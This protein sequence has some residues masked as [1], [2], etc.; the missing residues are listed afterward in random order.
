MF[1]PENRFYAGQGAA[2][3]AIGDVDGDQS[4][5]LVVLRGASS[6]LVI[7]RGY[8]DGTFGR[9]IR[10]EAGDRPTA[11]AVADLNGDGRQ[12]LAV[13]NRRSNSISILLGEPGEGVFL[14][15]KRLRVGK[16]PDSVVA[17]DFNDDDVQDQAAVNH[18]SGDMSVL[19]G[20]GGGRFR[21]NSR[22]GFLWQ[23]CGRYRLAIRCR[24]HQQDSPGGQL[25]H[26]CRQGLPDLDPGQ[27]LSH[28][29]VSLPVDRSRQHRVVQAR[30]RRTSRPEAGKAPTLPSRSDLPVFYRLQPCAPDI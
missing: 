9:E 5:D 19:I 15:Q 8:G 16:A 21:T 24:K 14:A 11:V 22:H 7:L 6:E 1:S 29:P 13:A 28:G 18:G 25:L 27:D 10:L 2:S 20:I 12:D 3:A 23:D 4:E 17:S 26:P 30:G